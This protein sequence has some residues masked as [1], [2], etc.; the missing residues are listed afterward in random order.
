MIEKLPKPKAPEKMCGRFTYNIDAVKRKLRGVLQFLG[1]DNRPDPLQGSE[2]PVDMQ[3]L[4]FEKRRAVTSN[5]R[6]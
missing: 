4:R 3:H 6:A 2:L 1:E 5:N